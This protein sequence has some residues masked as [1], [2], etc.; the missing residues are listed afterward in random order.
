ME[1]ND[2]GR[3]V[4]S[5]GEGGPNEEPTRGTFKS[6]VSGPIRGALIVVVIERCDGAPAK[7]PFLAGADDCKGREW[8]GRKLDGLQSESACLPW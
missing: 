7:P 2:Q 3:V 5:T 8:Q 6:R 4:D 1:M